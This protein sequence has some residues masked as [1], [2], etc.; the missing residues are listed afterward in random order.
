MFGEMADGLSLALL[1][2]GFAAGAA[3]LVVL[4]ARLALRRAP[5][6]YS[7]LLWAPVL[8]RLLCPFPIE[9]VFSLLPAKAQPIPKD[10]LYAGTPR[11]D[12]GFA[13]LD[14]AVNSVLPAGEPA[15][16]VNP[17]QV[18]LAAAQ[19]VWL[20]G[21]AVLLLYSLAA[22]LRL[23]RRLKGAAREEENIY[24]AAGL[25]TPFVMGLFRPRIYL[26]AGLAGE[27]RRYILLH[28]Q[29][30]IRRGDHLWRLLGFFALC[31]HWFNPLVWLAFYLSGKDMEMS[32]D[33]AVL[34]ALGENVKKPYS[35]SLLALASGR[36][37]V[38]GA[39]LAFGEGDTGARIKNVLRYRRPAFWVSAALL[40]V[41]AAAAVGLALSPRSGREIGGAPSAAPSV[42]ASSSEV[43]AVPVPL[44]EQE[45]VFLAAL[46]ASASADGGVARFTMPPE[47]P[48]GHRLDIQ[49]SAQIPRVENGVPYT[50]PVEGF[51]AQAE[52]TQAWQAG[53][54]YSETLIEGDIPDGSHIGFSAW[55][56][57]EDGIS[58]TYGHVGF[59]FKDGKAVR[60]IDLHATG[61]RGTEA[62]SGG[63]KRLKLEYT[64]SDGNFFTVA[65]ELPAAWTLAYGGEP[66]IDAYAP[67]DIYAADGVTYLGTIGYNLFEMPDWEAEDLHVPIYSGLMLGSVVSWD[68]DYTEVAQKGSV[69]AATCRVS[70]Q[71]G[72]AG[73][74]TTYRL[75]V[76]ARD[77]AL[78]RYIAL[79]LEPGA[80][81]G[82]ELEEIARSVEFGR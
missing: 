53:R 80:V 11:V 63:G 21:A 59:S 62:V 74:T 20:A 15:M 65:L 56:V 13:A 18:W 3:V 31:L 48:A 26:P 49:V 52:G 77:D 33:E 69:T 55:F 10:I 5:K 81:T 50:E 76:L 22:T 61:V 58:E 45:K 24:T 40:A 47:I 8:F 34:R 75:G 43:Q 73:G 6:L 19:L 29:T 44:E 54:A 51:Q 42:P 9:S 7:Y 27:E 25:E 16:S 39:P 66:R 36:R 30:H 41:V 72:G 68:N 79:Q 35:A 23:R 46:F 4:L 14:R 2:A 57:D 64:E 71:E 82:R 70:Y 1:N 28:E 37:W 60:E 38:G 67:V 17:L 12:T 78:G 32:C